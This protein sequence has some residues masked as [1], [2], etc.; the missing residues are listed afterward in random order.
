MRISDWSS[1]VCSSDL[2]LVALPDAA[3]P[4]QI[5][6]AK[7]KIEGVKDLIDKG[8]MDFTAAAIRYS[9]AP[10]ALQGGVLAWRH[11]N[12]IPNLL[13]NV[14]AAMK[15]CDITAPVR[16]PTV[17]QLIHLIDKIGRAS[18]WYRLCQSFYFSLFD[19]SL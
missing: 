17:F 14:L 1:D 5:A 15:A 10:D 4:E 18:C 2:I 11:Q 12:E 3:T 9:D 7:S 19:E 13:T 16:G 6:T 8:E